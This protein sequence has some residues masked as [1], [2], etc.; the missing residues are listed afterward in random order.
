[1]GWKAWNTAS[2]V[3]FAPLSQSAFAGYGLKSD[4]QLV[5][6]FLLWPSQSAFAG[7]GLKSFATQPLV[8][9]L[10]LS[11]SAFAGYGL[12][13]FSDLLLGKVVFVAIRFR[14]IW[15]EKRSWRPP[16]KKKSS[17]NPLSLDMGWKVPSQNSSSLAKPVAIRFRWIWVEKKD[18]N[19]PIE[20]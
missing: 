6:A 7:Y 11:Q 17:R 16:K 15:V 1:M 14:W 5:R 3:T 4:N 8:N 2:F 13:S 19:T 18:R 10:L 9:C 20:W 12:K